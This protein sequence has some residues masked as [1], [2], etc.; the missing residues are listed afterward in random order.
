ME[1]ETRSVT[2]NGSHQSLILVQFEASDG[3]TVAFVLSSP[4]LLPTWTLSISLSS[5]YHYSL[6]ESLVESRGF[7]PLASG[8]CG[9]GR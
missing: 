8:I 7:N 6:D 2:P 5:L 1:S 9:E 3:S 4:D